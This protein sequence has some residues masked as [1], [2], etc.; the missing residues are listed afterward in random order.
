ML[1]PVFIRL[2]M[3]LHVPLLACAPAGQGNVATPSPSPIL[4]PSP[5]AM[6]SLP[7][8]TPAATPTPTASL[9]VNPSAVP[10]NSPS[11][12]PQASATPVPALFE[13]ELGKAFDL[14]MGK[15]AQLK[16]TDLALSWISP[17]QDSR[18]PSDVNC[19][20]AGEVKVTV[21][22]KNGQNSQ[23]LNL[24]LPGKESQLLSAEMGGY[25]LTL[26]DVK[27]YPQAKNPSKETPRLNLL[28][29]QTEQK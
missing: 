24:Q 23:S 5:S 1:K 17:A 11:P 19:V 14:P 16:N 26:N 8:A 25:L 12:S 15:M 6:A 10:V 4:S 2:L 13:V 20:W 27:P 29:S 28:L 3:A 21:M 22:V 7:P 18:C 9:F